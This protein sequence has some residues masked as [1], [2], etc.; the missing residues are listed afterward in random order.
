MQERL[1]AGMTRRRFFLSGGG[2]VAVTLLLPELSSCRPLPTPGEPS[3][4]S[5]NIPQRRHRARRRAR[6]RP[7]RSD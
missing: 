7:L 6:R 5:R 4:S 2:G 1:P 3:R